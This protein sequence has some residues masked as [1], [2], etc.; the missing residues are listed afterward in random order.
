[1]S[2]GQRAVLAS[3]LV[4]LTTVSRLTAMG[5][6]PQSD[7]IP[8]PTKMP[9][10][11]KFKV[12][13]FT[14][15]RVKHS[16]AAGAL[17]RSSW[18]T[19]YPDSDLNLSA[20]FAKETQLAIDPKG[21][22]LTLTDPQLKNFPFIYL[23]EPGRLFLTDEE[24][25]SL[26]A[27]LLG[28]GFLM[29]DDFW[30]ADEWEHFAAEFKKVFPDRQPEELPLDHPVFRAF[31]TIDEKPQVPSIHAALAGLTTERFGAEEAHY[32]GVTDD[33]GRLM[34]IICHNTDLGDGWER[35]D[36][37][38]FY[39]REFSQKRAYPMGIN[40]VVY[41]LMQPIEAAEKK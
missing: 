31:H 32:R 29:V 28:G 30:G 2:T 4:M 27:Y 34:A 3:V 11:L 21:K 7:A 24:A 17:R 22:V 15:V 25:K 23:V 16:D 18:A 5:S 36:A 1:M 13:S 10:D 37:D 39:F 35:Q 9:A 12:K 14:F 8:Q 41:A 19:D 26:R 33:R 6:E 38:A 40:I 20:R